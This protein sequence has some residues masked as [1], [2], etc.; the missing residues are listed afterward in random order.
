MRSGFD[1]RSTHK[2]DY[3]HA[4]FPYIYHVRTLHTHTHTHIHTQHARIKSIIP[5][6]ISRYV[7]LYTFIKYTRFSPARFALYLSWTYFTLITYLTPATIPVKFPLRF[8]L[9]PND[10]IYIYVSSGNYLIVLHYAQRFSN[11]PYNSRLFFQKNTFT[12]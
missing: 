12:T 11:T 5:M 8:L 10:Y 6:H 3:F 9:R 2:I 4:H 1:S 7:S